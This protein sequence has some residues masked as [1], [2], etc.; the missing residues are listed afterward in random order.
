M[1]HERTIRLAT[2]KDA[3]RILALLKTGLSQM[4]ADGNKNQWN[5]TTHSM[6]SVLADIERSESYVV[7][8]QGGIIATFVFMLRAEPTY[9]A[10]DG[11]WLR[12]APYVTIHR[13]AS[14]GHRGG[15]ARLVFDWALQWGRDLRVDTHHDN[16]RMQHLF[17]QYG[18]VY[19]GIIH[20]ADGTPR[21]AYHLAI[22]V[23]PK[24]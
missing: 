15:I 6:E 11:A 18:F 9:A 2:H 7:V 14:D 10:I 24:R 1:K 21:R 20:L 16:F 19:C 22:G 17:L 4:R 8:E 3:P 13:L 12:N 23:L 5:D